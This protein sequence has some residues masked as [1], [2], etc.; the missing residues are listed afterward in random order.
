MKEPVIKPKNLEKF[1]LGF[2]N[3][4]TVKLDSSGHFPQEEHPEI[5]LK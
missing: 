2:N 4:T 3:A 1:K 5:V